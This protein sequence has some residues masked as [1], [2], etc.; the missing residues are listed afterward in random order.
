MYRINLY[1]EYRE[2]RQRQRSRTAAGGVLLALL[3]LEVLMVGALVVSD[4]LLNER[5]AA[6]RSELPQL[7]ARLQANTRERP[8]LDVALELIALREK[9]V[10][11]TPKLAAV[12]EQCAAGMKL[13]EIQGRTASK[14]E[15]P[16][17]EINGEALDADGALSVVSS[18]LER[19]RADPRMTDDFPRVDLGNIRGGGSG[20]FAV[21]CAPPEVKE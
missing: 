5:A 10:D 14:R 4:H 19:L 20:E 18:Y 15:R 7:T 12:A 17:F 1:P 13:V 21:L 8:E 6:L 3:G 11:W 2:R 16:R 9:R